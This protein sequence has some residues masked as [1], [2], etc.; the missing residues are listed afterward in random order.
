LNQVPDLIELTGYYRCPSDGGQL[1]P[2]AEGLACVLC[3]R[4][5]PLQKHGIIDFDIVKSDQRLAFDEKQQGKRVLSAAETEASRT[6]A[7][8]FLATAGLLS[9]G[10]LENKNILMLFG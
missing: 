8:R 6:V 2:K 1:S 7:D 10:T 4:H 3:N 9:H 5:F